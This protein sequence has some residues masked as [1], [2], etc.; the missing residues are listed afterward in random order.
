MKILRLR[1]LPQRILKTRK[2]KKD[3]PDGQ[4]LP[5][6]NA[7]VPLSFIILTAENFSSD[8][9]TKRES[10]IAAHLVRF[11]GEMKRIHPSPKIAF[12]SCSGVVTAIRLYFS[13]KMRTTPGER[14]AGRV[15]PSRMFW[16]PSASSAMRMQTAFC[17]NQQ[18]TSESNTLARRFVR[19]ENGEAEPVFTITSVTGDYASKRLLDNGWQ[20]LRRKGDVTYFCRIEDGVNVSRE[21]LQ[22]MFHFIRVDWNTGETD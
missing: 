11:D 22:E 20:E 19:V 17:S 5:I 2:N 7:F 4:T 15:G 3:A 13:C 8:S 14:K 16:M 21:E 6:W 12:R 1:H 9:C 10:T 18:S